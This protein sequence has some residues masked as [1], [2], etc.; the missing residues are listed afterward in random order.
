MA[1][2]NLLLKRDLHLKVF[3]AYRPLSVQKFMVQNTFAEFRRRSDLSKLDDSAILEE[4]HKLWSP[5]RTESSQ[6]PPHSTG[7]AVDLTL[8]NKNGDLLEM[9]C[10]IDTAGAVQMPDYFKDINPIINANRLL[11]R[12]TMEKV[13][14]SA[15]FFE[16]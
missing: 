15:L 12:S 7:G 8:I 16:W 2:E 1:A 6:P 14:F 10:Q 9:G 3:D 4:V 5:P 11:L 13:G